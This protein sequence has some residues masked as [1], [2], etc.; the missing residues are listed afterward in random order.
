[1]RYPTRLRFQ[2]WAVASFAV[3]TLWASATP[4]TWW[5]NAAHAQAPAAAARGGGRRSR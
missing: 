1:M 2:I 3:L 4:G 5:T